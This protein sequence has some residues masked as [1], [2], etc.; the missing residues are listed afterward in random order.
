MKTK[1]VMSSVLAM[2]IGGFMSLSVAA[3][4]TT[5]ATGTPATN[6]DPA[7]TQVQKPAAQVPPK[8]ETTDPRKEEFVKG[9]NE[10]QPK[11]TNYSAKA[12]E[13]KNAELTTEA[14]KLSS[15]VN[16]FR[17]KVNRWDN[18]PDAQK[19]QFYQTLKKEWDG[20]KAQQ[21]KVEGLWAKSNPG[22]PQEKKETP[23]ESPDKK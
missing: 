22:Q 4:S 19:D 23:K 10:I 3:Q 13:S 7:K 15:M 20:V 16:E 8:Q 2:A 18:T 21:A 17:A 11:V 9:L 1:H 5:P 12:Q 14:N 6:P